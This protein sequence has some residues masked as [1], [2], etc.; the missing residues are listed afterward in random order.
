MNPKNFLWVQT[1][2]RSLV[3][4]DARILAP[5]TLRLG[6]RTNMMDGAERAIGPLTTKPSL[7][8]PPLIPPPWAENEL[9][10]IMTVRLIQPLRIARTD[11]WNLSADVGAYTYGLGH[12]MKPQ[13]MRMTHELVS[14]YDMLDKMHVLVRY[15]TSD[16]ECPTLTIGLIPPLAAS[17]TRH[18]RV[19]DQVPHRRIRTLFRE[20]HTGNSRAVDISREPM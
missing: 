6:R 3:I 7:A 1:L 2:F 8:P 12:P 11:H 13:R 14:A 20:G 9:Y 4:G 10:T 5:A 16:S 15:P 17:K 18:C 19:N